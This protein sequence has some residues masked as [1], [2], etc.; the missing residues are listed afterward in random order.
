M[1]IW[2]RCCCSVTE[3][4]YDERRLVEMPKILQFALIRQNLSTLW[5]N[6]LTVLNI[7]KLRCQ[8][9]PMELPIV[10][11][12]KEF[13][14][15]ATVTCSWFEIM[16]EWSEH[17]RVPRRIWLLWSKLMV[18]ITKNRLSLSR[19]RAKPQSKGCSD[20]SDKSKLSSWLSASETM[21]RLVIS[22]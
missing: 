11:R 12:L 6:E 2:A 10:Y 9:I 4:V 21:F 5:S 8:Y 3:I 18:D 22:V 13:A 1:V 16:V 17:I 14:S 20:D 19:V 7:S 15:S